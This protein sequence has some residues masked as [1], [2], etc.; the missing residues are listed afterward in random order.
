MRL[1][2]LGIIL[3]TSSFFGFNQNDQFMIH[4][5]N[6]DYT[7]QANVEEF[8]ANPNFSVQELVNGSYFRMLQFKQN[9]SKKDQE[10]L[11]AAGIQLYGYLPEKTY[12]AAL[13]QH[14]NLNLLRTKT[15]RSV[16]KIDKQFSL[17]KALY[18]KKYPDWALRAENRIELTAIHFDDL[19]EVAAIAALEQRGAEITMKSGEGI[20]SFICPIAE[21]DNFYSTPGFYYFEAI[22]APPQREDYQNVANHRSNYINNPEGVGK[23]YIGTGVTVMMQDDGVIGPHIDYQGRLTTEVVGNGGDHGDHVA[24]IIMGA[25]NLDPDVVGNAPGA[26]LMVYSPQNSNYNFVPDLY[27]ND[28]LVITAKSYGDGNNAGY[29]ILARQLDQQCNDFDALVHVFSAG[30]SGTSNFG[31]GAGAGW[32]NITGGHKQGKNVLAVGNLTDTDQLNFSSSR[33]PADDGRIKPNICAVGTSVNSTIDPN[34]YDVKTG[35]SMSC[36]G[37][38]GSIAIL[39]EAYRD[40]NDGQNPSAALVNAAIMNTAEDLGNPGPDFEFGW[41]RINVRRAYQILED[42]SYQFSNIAESET[43]SHLIEVPEG[44]KQVRVMVYWTDYPASP[45]VSTALVNDLNMTMTS[46]SSTVYQPWVLNPTPSPILLDRDAEPGVD[47]LN[48][49]EQITI[50]DPAAGTY[51]IN[52]AGFDIPKGPQEYVVV[53]EFVQDEIVVTFPLGGESLIAGS[54]QL[55]RWDAIGE[56]ENFILEESF[57]GGLTWDQISPTLPGTRRSFPWNISSSTVTGKAQIR[58]KRG[59]QIGQSKANIS[60][61]RQPKNLEVEWACPQSFNFSWDPVPGAIGYEVFLLGEKYMDSA[62]Y[63]TETNATVYANSLEPQWYSVRAIGPD[64]CIGQR[65]IAVYKSPFISG[66]TLEPP[67]ADFTSVCNKIG[68]GSCVQF[69]D[70]STNAGQGAAW[71]WSFPGGTPATSQ[72]ENPY[73]CYETEGNYDVTLTVKNGVGEDL[74]T[75]TQYVEVRKGEGLP[76]SEDFEF[77]QV[78]ASWSIENEGNTV[79][80]RLDNRVSAY[81]IGSNAIVFDNLANSSAGSTASFTTQQIDLKGTP[82]IMELSFDVAYAKGLSAADSLRVY[83]TNNCGVTKQLLYSSGGEALATAAATNSPFVPASTEWK[84]E[85]IS[86]AE[87]TEWTSASLIFENYSGNGNA[88]YID[89]I[90]L[91]VSEENFSADLISVFP[92]PFSSEISI[93]GLVDG[94]ETTIRIHSVK[95]DVVYE[96]VFEAFSGTIVLPTDYFADGMYVIEITSPSKTNKLK[97]IKAQN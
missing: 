41:G 61:I 64:N 58:V 27:L 14:A 88:L 55:V 92:N 36:P 95:G 17:S 10:E 33:G 48:N 56:D 78:P 22:G 30:N 2:T 75:W 31:Y 77:G 23:G 85:A 70:I 35:T 8:I 90:N 7:P 24:G 44:T 93:A 83:I 59:T 34:T 72:V 28:D 84:F 5:K 6:G 89:N 73:V 12:Y 15:V 37:V 18:T 11:A 21:V 1:L 57:D 29:T 66:C 76:F 54:L 49:M 16:I 40:L 80:W 60:I 74:Y 82:S 79:N 91:R 4:L 25:G 52:I 38:A 13:S 53:Y 43:N 47:D 32:G 67:V 63:T 20:V 68:D 42:R 45:A 26:H 39:Y 81:N 94:E 51:T 3:L 50:D 71:E 69:F 97:L 86:L 9:P 87:F 19:T 65:A 62:G 96:N 46:P